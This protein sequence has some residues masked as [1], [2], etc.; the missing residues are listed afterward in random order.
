VPGNGN[1]GARSLIMLNIFRP[2]ISLIIP[3]YNQISS[4]EQSLRKISA[5]PVSKELIVIDDFSDDGS[6]ELLK[7][8]Q[9]E[10]KLKLIL[11]ALHRGRGAAIINGSAHAKGEFVMI[12][13]SDPDTDF[14]YL[15][16][17]IKLAELGKPDLMISGFIKQPFN[18]SRSVNSLLIRLLFGKKVYDAASVY[19][20]CR[21]SKF[22]TMHFD[23]AVKVLEVSWLLKAL[24]RGM[25]LVEVELKS[26][27][28]KKTGSVESGFAIMKEIL[29]LR[30]SRK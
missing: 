22:Q 11:H 12:T 26:E 21:L 24:Q 13:E 19:K 4:I 17:L 30:F 18:F 25:N 20:I 23:P 29:T 27:S 10:L 7:Q 14:L 2:K 8:L 28:H 3:V 1:K 6:K 5:L 9:P 15:T 16:E